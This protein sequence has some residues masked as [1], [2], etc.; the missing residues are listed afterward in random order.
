MSKVIVSVV[1]INYNVK[2]LILSSLDSLYKNKS[3]HYFLEIIVVD[4]HSNDGSCEA[5]LESYPNVHLIK[6]ASN[7]GFPKANNQGFEIAKG[8]YIFMLNP[9]TELME[10][11]IFKMLNFMLENQRYDILAPKLLNSDKSHQYSV[12]KFPTLISIY[13]EMHYLNFLLK[14]KNYTNQNFNQNF[15]VESCSGAAIFFKRKVLED[16]GMLDETMFWIEDIDFCYRALKKGYHILYFPQTQIIHHI[17]QS[18]KKN[19][20][21]SLS[22]QIFNKI[23]FFKKHSS[24]ASYQLVKLMSFYHV[25]S[26]IVVFGLFSPFKAI[27]FLKFQAYIYTLPKV[28]NPPNGIK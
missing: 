5:I 22:N 24:Y 10:D 26:K 27:Y 19:Y 13:L 20:K 4:N 23:K 15:E 9:D 21:I 8:D 18:A 11:S 14:K 6:N 2:D 28:Y 25:L 16:V 7:K 12:W 17:G 1:I 3:E